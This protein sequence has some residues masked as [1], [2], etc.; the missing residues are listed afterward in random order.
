[1]HVAGRCLT[2]GWFTEP[3]SRFPRSGRTGA[4]L[5]SQ[6]PRRADAAPLGGALSAYPARPGLAA[7]AICRGRRALHSVEALITTA[8]LSLWVFTLDDLFDEE[9]VP[10]GSWSGGPYRAIACNECR[11]TTPGQPRRR[12]HEVRDDLARYPLF[13]SLGEEWANALC[14]TIDGMVREYEWRPCAI[15]TMTRGAAV[16]RGIH[17]HR[18][19]QHRRAA[20]RLGGADHHR[21]RPRHPQHLDQLATHGAY[22]LDLHPPGERPS[23]PPQGGGRREDQRPGHPRRKLGEADSRPR[24]RPQ[25]GRQERVARRHPRCNCHDRRP[26]QDARTITDPRGGHRRYRPLCVRLLHQHDYHTFINGP[27]P[28]ARQ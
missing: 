8:R 13:A 17:R 9:R 12:A 6:R 11:R 2:L 15:A 14:G 18:A 20:P 4:H 16:V 24:T 25:A 5:R 1:M 21:R 22:R 7:R 28:M 23:E 19:V 26:A 10:E 27:A 3:L